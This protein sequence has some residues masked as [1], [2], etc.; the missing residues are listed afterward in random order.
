MTKGHPF[1]R[2]AFFA[3]LD[4]LPDVSY[5]PEKRIEVAVE[6]LEQGVAGVKAAIEKILA[7]PTAGLDT[8]PKEDSV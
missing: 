6:P 3:A 2:E 4:S 7:Q 1:D 8:T 5:F